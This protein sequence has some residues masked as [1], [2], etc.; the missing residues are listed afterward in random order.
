[1]KKVITYICEECVEEFNE[2]QIVWALSDCGKYCY[3]LCKK[4][5]DIRKPTEIKNKTEKR[6][7]RVKQKQYFKCNKCDHISYRDK[8]KEYDIRQLCCTKC[9]GFKSLEKIRKPRK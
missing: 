3:V 1:M 6:K 4:C 9:G 2:N 8:K 7:V 5:V